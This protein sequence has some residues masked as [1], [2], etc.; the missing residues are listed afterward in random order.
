MY[1]EPAE[2][3]IFENIECEWPVF[4]TYFILDGLFTG[5]H[6]QVEEY[7]EKL[8]EIVLRDE[9]GSVQIPELYYV[10]SGKVRRGWTLTLYV[11]FDVFSG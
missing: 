2:L 8:N 9:T 6:E 10:S 3:K 4:F 7:R 5:R 11:F 1:Y